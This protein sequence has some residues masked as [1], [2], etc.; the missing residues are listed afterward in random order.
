MFAGPTGTPIMVG[1]GVLAYTMLGI[2]H[3][4]RE[5]VG[6]LFDLIIDASNSAICFCCML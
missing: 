6:G 1:G 4:V 5:G 3:H 2:D